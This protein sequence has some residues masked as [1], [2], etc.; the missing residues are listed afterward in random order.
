M[1]SGR[2]LVH[3][4]T[5]EEDAE[6]SIKATDTSSATASD[7]T[8]NHNNTVISSAFWTEDEAN[9]IA[10]LPLVNNDTGWEDKRSETD[11]NDDNTN[12]SSVNV[13]NRDNKTEIE[14][15][16]PLAIV[17]EIA[18]VE[19]RE[20]SPEEWSSKSELYNEEGINKNAFEN[21]NRPKW[22]SSPEK[23]SAEAE[24][25]YTTDRVN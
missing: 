11:S 12:K 18:S 3:S 1:Y 24:Q 7:R 21:I 10:S 19:R 22:Y 2:Y 9:I 13:D 16:V 8:S 17:S 23:G 15:T 4:F 20:E 14:K 6:S 5:R 25:T